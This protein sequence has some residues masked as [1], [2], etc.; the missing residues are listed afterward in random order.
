MPKPNK[1]SKYRNM[2][3]NPVKG[4]RAFKKEKAKAKYERKRV[5]ILNVAT[6]RLSLLRA[7]RS[8]SQL[9]RAENTINKI[10]TQLENLSLNLV[11]LETEP[12]NLQVQ[13]QVQVYE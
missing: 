3:Y 1:S 9:T 7:K 11:D 4:F 12:A 10:A 5:H 2:R 8:T 6:V 13:A